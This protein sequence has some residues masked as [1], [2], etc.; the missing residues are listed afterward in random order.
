MIL[1]VPTLETPRLILRGWRA[2]DFA[3]YAA[4][5]ADPETARF[6]T[7]RGEPCSA[8]QSWAEIAFFIGHWQLRGCGMFV[9][10]ARGTGAFLGRVGALCPEGWPGFEIG[11]ALAPAARGQGY[12]LEAARAATGWSFA[13][14]P[15]E[16]IVSLIDPRNAASRKLAG[17][18][19]ERRSEERFAPFGT[20]LDVWEL[21]REDWLRP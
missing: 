15:I 14:F 5:L 17:R 2:E 19:G 16:R 10:E 8:A 6:I 9:V 7:R 11:W 3:P 21:H 20:P 18:L 13:T 12:A 4:M 1:S